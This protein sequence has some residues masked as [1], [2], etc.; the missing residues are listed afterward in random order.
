MKRTSM[1]AIAGAALCASA[2]A[3][4][5]ANATS[6]GQLSDRTKGKPFVA[7]GSRGQVARR[8]QRTDRAAAQGWHNAA[9]ARP[10]CE[11]E[12]SGQAG[13]PRGQWEDYPGWRWNGDPRWQW[14]GYPRWLWHG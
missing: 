12:P 13:D 3:L 11:C 10:R 6:S 7:H 4:S 1:S 2:I 9:R 14:D 5:A 8:V